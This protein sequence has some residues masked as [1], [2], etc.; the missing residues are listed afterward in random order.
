V[1]GNKNVKI[2]QKIKTIPIEFASG[3][4][5]TQKQLIEKRRENNSARIKT[6]LH[7][8]LWLFCLIYWKELLCG[9]NERGIER[10]GTHRF[11][12]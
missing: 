5:F 1:R 11:E 10:S 9:L 6:K 4:K 3:S 2:E 8:N 7:Q 12:G